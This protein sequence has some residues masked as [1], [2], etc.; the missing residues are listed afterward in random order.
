VI[1][2]EVRQILLPKPREQ[3]FAT[4]QPISKGVS[5]WVA[6]YLGM[7]PR[8]P[9]PEPLDS[10]AFRTSEG[11]ARGL[12]KTRLTSP[13][14]QSPFHGV[15][16]RAAP[17]TLDALCR[18][19]LTRM[20]A[21]AFFS[22]TTAANLMKLPLPWRLENERTLHVAVPSPAT[23]SQARGITGHK[24]HLMGNDSRDWHGLPIS[25]PERVFCELGA[26][27]SLA[28]LVAVGDHLIHWRTPITSI[29]R[30][31]DAVARY[32][33][34][35]GKAN[36][37][38]ALALLDPRAES[39]KES[40]TRVFLVEAG[41]EGFACNYEVVVD[42]KSYRIDIAFPKQK[43]ALEYQGDYH[44]DSVQWRKDMSRDAAIASVGWTTSWINADDLNDPT[45]LAARITR[46]LKG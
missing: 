33:G 29:E 25:T 19:F 43:L 26:V 15:K 46:L 13:D 38:H 41:I 14:L 44:R 18:A 4:L 28:D 36:L 10:R 20:P 7:N 32:P 23:A 6:K 5:R 31:A 9:I 21:G 39:P 35:R 16:V 22:S 11:V 42:G 2:R 8:I 12:G 24:V 34:R 1:P 27:L 17:L 3:G 37:Q 30:L 45:A 40:H